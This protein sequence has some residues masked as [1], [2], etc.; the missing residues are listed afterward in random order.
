MSEKMRTYKFRAWHKL[1]KKMLY[2]NSDYRGKVFQWLAEAQP[3]EI[4]QFT[5]LLDL[6]GKEIWEGDILLTPGK[7]KL[8]VQ[9]DNIGYGDPKFFNIGFDIC[10]VI[11]NIY[12]HSYL[13]EDK[14]AKRD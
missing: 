13:L 10:E 12:E 5:G 11:G 14:N 9:I 3:L 4:M 6:K 7:F 2:E 8:T 1:S